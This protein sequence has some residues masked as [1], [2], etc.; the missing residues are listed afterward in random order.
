MLNNEPDT[1]EQPAAGMG[2]QSGQFRLY[3]G[4]G[5]GELCDQCGEPIRSDQ[6]GYEL[7]TEIIKVRPMNIHRDCYE[8]WEARFAV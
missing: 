6:V 1:R 2:L 4:K 3:A 8:D 7:V 5:N